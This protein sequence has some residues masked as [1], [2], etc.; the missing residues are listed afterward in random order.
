M[1]KIKFNRPILIEKDYKYLEGNEERVCK[2]IKPI[3]NEIGLIKSYVV[4]DL[5][6]K[7]EKEVL[8]ENI[9]NY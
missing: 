7:E 2:I 4:M 1:K 6:S 5:K 3:F 9:I 8:K